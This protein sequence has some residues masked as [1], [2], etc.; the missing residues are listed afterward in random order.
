MKEVVPGITWLLGEGYDSN[1][2]I[3]ES[4]QDKLMIDSGAG[5]LIDQRF[6]SSSQSVE[7]LQNVI[8]LR[9]CSASNTE[10]EISQ[11]LST[12]RSSQSPS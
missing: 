10:A 3:I 4:D 11:L 6:Q 12:W 8:E 5:K 2:Y 1:V 9:Y 7:Q